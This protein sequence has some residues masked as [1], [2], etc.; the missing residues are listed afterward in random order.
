MSPHVSMCLR[1]VSILLPYCNEAGCHVY[2]YSYAGGKDIL[3]YARQKRKI[4]ELKRK[5]LESEKL[6]QESSSVLSEKGI[7]LYA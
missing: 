4:T 5:G 6:N 3:I 1:P 7:I 2:Y